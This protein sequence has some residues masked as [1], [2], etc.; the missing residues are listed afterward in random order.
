MNNIYEYEKELSYTFNSLYISKCKRKRGDD[1]YKESEEYEK[2][3]KI[4]EDLMSKKDLTSKEDV[5][6]NEGYSKIKKGVY[7]RYNFIKIDVSK[8]PSYIL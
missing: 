3:K 8:V 2:D 7:K 5:T 1:V 4:K 6:L